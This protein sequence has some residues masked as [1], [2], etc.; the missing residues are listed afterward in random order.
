MVTRYPRIG[1]LAARFR[2]ALSPP[3]KQYGR[4]SWDEGFVAQVHDVIQQHL[5]DPLYTTTAAATDLGMSRM[6]L[7]RR[8]RALTG[9]STHEFIRAIR[10]D[11][12]REMLLHSNDPVRAVA[13]AVGFSSTSHFA[14]AFCDRFGMTPSNFRMQRSR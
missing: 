11:A 1:F 6:H 9:K 2:S 8:L 7:N 13:A 10:L 3:T 12:A 5:G 4:A 14:H